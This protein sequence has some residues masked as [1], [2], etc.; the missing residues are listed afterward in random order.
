MTHFGPYST[1]RSVSAPWLD[2]IPA[3][4]DFRPLWSLTS[5]NEESLAE[6][7]SPDLEIRYVDISSV[8]Q[9]TG[10]GKYE[11]M[12]FGDTPSR[13]RRTGRVGD[14][15]VSTVR[16]YL[17]AVA[18][19]CV[20]HADCVFSTGF[21]VLRAA[22]DCEPDFLRWLVLND[23]FIQAVEAHSEG[24][25]YPAINTSALTRL[26][27]PLP[28]PEE[29]RAISRHLSEATIRIDTLIEKKIRFIE[30]LKEKRQA[31]ISHAVTKGLNPDAP[32]KDSGIEWLGEL[33]AHWAIVPSP[34][35]FFEC[36][37]RAHDSD[38]QLSATQKYG[39]IPRAEFE[40][41]EGRRVTHATMHLEL[42]KH[43]EVGDF[44]IS[45]R[46]FEGGI[47]RVKARGCVRSSYVVLRAKSRA[48]IDFYSH[49]FKSSLYI[50]GLQATASFIRDGQDLS[51]ANFRQVNLPLPPV[52]EQ[53]DIALF[54][55]AEL[56]RIDSLQSLT[57]RSIDLLIERRSSLITAA[58]TGKIDLRDAA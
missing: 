37:E 42:R 43:A 6:S 35:L 13:A 20:E 38:E 29:Q 32:L 17:K 2:A 4:W 36:K 51:Y 54:L 52:E 15:L 24:L 8:N 12:R 27:V 18:P 5:C 21:A 40:R 14:V 47:E 56:V 50:Q 9:S 10:I 39:V 30:L 22:Q 16:T 57:Q 25:S 3:H 26:K 55:S 41:L 11:V 28:P 53:S 34:W 48:N 1:F 45:M 23:C 46:S 58:V 33:P 31:L 44:V 19:I 7:T 49:L